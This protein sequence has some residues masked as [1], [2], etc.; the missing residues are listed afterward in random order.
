[1]KK[2]TTENDVEDLQDRMLAQLMKVI[3]P[4]LKVDLVNLGL[5]YGLSL[6]DKVCTVK[7]TLT[8]M[9]CPIS[10][11]LETMI[12][13]ALEQLPEIDEVKIDLVWEPAWSPDKMS[14][15]ARYALGYY[16]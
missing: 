1:M 6:E 8:T 15:N 7:M 2:V 9:G 16:R 13:S 14:R 11:V 4:E 12:Q 5:I 10:A 3:D